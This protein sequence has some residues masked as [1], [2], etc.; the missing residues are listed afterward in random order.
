MLLLSGDDLRLCVK[1]D[2]FFHFADETTS[3]SAD[4]YPNM[5]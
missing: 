3:G 1:A 2:S 5:D 4:S